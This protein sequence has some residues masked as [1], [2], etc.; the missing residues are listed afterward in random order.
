MKDIANLC[1]VS[2][3]T[4]SYV[5]NKT[6]RVS[7]E[8]EA[9]VLKAI[10]QT[11]YR[12]NT[13]AQS[14]R[15]QKTNIIGVL[16]EDIRG[17]P[18]PGIVDGIDEFLEGTGYQMLLSNLRLLDKLHN[19]YDQLASHIETI[20]QAMRLMENAR[21][22]GIVYVAMHDRHITGIRQPVGIPIVYA[23][24]T[25]GAGDAPSVTYENE[26]SAFELTR[27][28]IAEGH[29]RIALVAGHS[30]SIGAKQRLAG[31]SRAM[32]E[33]GL[34]VPAEYIRWGDWEYPSGV[35]QCDALMDLHVRPT[36][37]FAMSD[38]MATGCYR[39]IKNH[40][41][42]IP[43]DISVAGF[44]NRTFAQMINP[45]L[46]TVELPN[47]QI[48]GRAAALLLGRI[49]DKDLPAAA[50]VIPCRIIARESTAPP[51]AGHI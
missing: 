36:A 41:L 11:N 43:Q 38:A 15:M 4:V 48:G 47:R 42:R 51:Q 14:L 12:P 32:E 7:P 49:D 10:K 35:T 18:V 3:A 29:E 34:Y 44:D 24:A 17:L 8:V 5:I 1:G 46:T 13:I 30:A 27:M 31:F 23:Y 2:V 45:P 39:S 33:A 19:R 20:N 9:R 25:S 16:V 50:E 40:G 26:R 6:R 22:D 21:V 37:V 28:L